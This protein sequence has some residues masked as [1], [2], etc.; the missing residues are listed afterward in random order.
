MS[1]PKITHPIHEFEVPSLKKKF[2]FRPFLVK[3]E[4]FLL[5]AKTSEDR[6]EIVRAM[7]QLINNCCESPNF[8]MHLLTLFDIEYLFLKLRAV[9]VNNVAEIAYRDAEDNEI[10]KFQI[11]LHSVTVMFPENVES[12][13]KIN[14]DM[15]L[16]MKFIPADIIDDKEFFNSDEKEYFY[17]TIIRCVDKLYHGDEVFDLSTT[18]KK[19]VEEFLDSCDLATFEKIRTFMENQPKLYHKLEY[20][21]KLNNKKVIELTSLLDFFTLG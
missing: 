16:T 11:D 20:T 12:T 6:I 8:N 21:N 15:I 3:E 18:P 5:M 13:I 9:S 19:E 14:D 17:E 10:Y 2:I 7:K 4:K 1:L